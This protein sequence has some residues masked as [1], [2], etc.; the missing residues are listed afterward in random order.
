[1]LLEKIDKMEKELDE[2][3]NELSNKNKM[4]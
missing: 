2:V 4:N 1:M 3:K